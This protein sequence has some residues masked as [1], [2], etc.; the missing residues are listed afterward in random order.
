[1]YNSIYLATFMYSFVFGPNETA[2]VFGIALEQAQVL[3]I[4]WT[5]S[6]NIFAVSCRLVFRPEPINIGGGT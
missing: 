4:P 1:M 2:K 3:T 5:E 6:K